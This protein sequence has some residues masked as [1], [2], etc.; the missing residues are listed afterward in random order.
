MTDRLQTR[1]SRGGNVVVIVA[2]SLVAVLGVAAVAIDGGFA[3]YHRVELQNASD[4][5]AHAAVLAFDGTEEGLWTAR[6]AAVSIA[7][8]NTAAGDPVILDPNEDNDPAGDIVSGYWDAETGA[9]TAS[10]D[11]ELV[12][13][14]R[15][16]AR[17]EALQTYFAGAAFG[18]QDLVVSVDTV[19]LKPEALPAG[20]VDCYLPLAIPACRI[21]QYGSGEILDI[22]FVLNPDG[23]DNVGWALLGSGSVSASTLEEQINNCQAS[24]EVQNASIVSLNNGAINTVL[25]AMADAVGDSDTVW[26]DE[27]W[28]TQG[29]PMEKSLVDKNGDYGNTFEGPIIVFDEQGQPCDEVKFTQDYPVKGFYWA[30]VYDVRSKGAAAEKNIRVRIDTTAEVDVGTRSGGEYDDGILYQPPPRIV[31]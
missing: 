22:D 2:L 25:S 17:N 30:A 31:Q 3:R 16:T 13:A 12:D 18:R 15:V 5:A 23:G 14:F 9:F 29:A 27:V 19:G 20:A 24:G 7:A 11:P 6:Q 26:R 10:L 1:P 28:G 4:A 8:L 21:E